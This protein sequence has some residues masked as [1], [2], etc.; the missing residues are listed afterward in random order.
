MSEQEIRITGEPQIDPQACKFVVDRP[1][2][3]GGMARFESYEEALG[4]PLAERLF[5]IEGISGVQI[6]EN[7]ILIH[8]STDDI[9]PVLG[10]SIGASIR[11]HVSSGAPAVSEDILAKAADSDAIRAAVQTVLTNE[12]N[13][14]VASHGGFIELLDVQGSTVYIRMG[15]G[16][17][18]C[19]MASVTLKQGVEKAIRAQVPEVGEILDTTDHAA[20]NNPFYAPSVK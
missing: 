18:G 10:K 11:E 9:W 19:G 12:I 3:P 7:S 15:G 6:A 14:G 4:S 8:K 20:G 5:G 1:L 13:P 2:L 16:C 17:Q